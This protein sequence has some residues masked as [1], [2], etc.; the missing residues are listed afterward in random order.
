MTEVTMPFP[1]VAA[2]SEVAIGTKG[3]PPGNDQELGSKQLPKIDSQLLG[4][5]MRRLGITT[6]KHDDR[7]PHKADSESL[8]ED[9]RR[10]GIIRTNDDWPLRTPV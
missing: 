5:D 1:D 7:P 6:K 8:G 4:N 3:L 9:M 10:F 2:T